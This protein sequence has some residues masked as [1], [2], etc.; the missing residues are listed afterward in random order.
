MVNRNKA[1][2]H[3]RF[4]ILSLYIL[5]VNAAT[6]RRYTVETWTDELGRGCRQ[7]MYLTL[8]SNPRASNVFLHIKENTVIKLKFIKKSWHHHRYA[9]II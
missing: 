3:L 2:I 4:K 9:F 7:A 6:T 1:S 5:G 8:K